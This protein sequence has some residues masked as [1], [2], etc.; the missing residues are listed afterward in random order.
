MKT[1]IA[2][3]IFLMLITCCITGA[4]AGAPPTDDGTYNVDCDYISDGSAPATEFTPAIL[5]EMQGWSV[6]A[7]GTVIRFPDPS[8][9]SGKFYKITS[10]GLGFVELPTSGI[11]G[12]GDD[13]P[14]SVVNNTQIN[15]PAGLFK[16]H[17]LNSNGR[18][19][20]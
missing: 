14:F 10:G 12:Y 18:P 4:Y 5:D 6:M 13:C 1:N 19:P 16:N 11:R 7:P 2:I 8:G 9:R 3:L 20:V 17:L 15:Y